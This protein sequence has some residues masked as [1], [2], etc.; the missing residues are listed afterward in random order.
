[1]NVILEAERKELF[2]LWQ[3]DR[4][5]VEGKYFAYLLFEHLSLAI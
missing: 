1:M 5:K 2:M 4:S 3:T